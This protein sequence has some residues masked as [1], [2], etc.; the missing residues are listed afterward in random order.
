M[1]ARVCNIVSQ[2]SSLLGLI[3]QLN[4]SSDNEWDAKNPCLGDQYREN[5]H[6]LY[7]PSNITRGTVFSRYAASKFWDGE[8]F[9]LGMK[10]N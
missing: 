9:V 10:S 4:F 2:F 1:Y 6:T 5:F 8:E 3:L 7:V